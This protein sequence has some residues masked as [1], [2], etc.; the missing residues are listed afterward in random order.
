[1]V[2]EYARGSENTIAD[3]LSRLTGFAGDE[4][5]SYELARGVPTFVC[6]VLD[7]DRLDLRVDWISAQRTD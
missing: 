6:L 5:I 3:I 7:A 1:M 2:I 4:S